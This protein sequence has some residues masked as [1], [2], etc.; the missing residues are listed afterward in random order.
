MGL[1][2]I[3]YSYEG[4]NCDYLRH[5][6][7]CKCGRYVMIGT[8][9]Y[10]IKMLKKNNLLRQDYMPICCYCKK[11]EE[12]EVYARNNRERDGTVQRI[13]K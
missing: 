5:S 9:C 11:K 3:G 2:L 6:H 1:E 12:L 7:L 13:S 8:Y 10:I 4:D